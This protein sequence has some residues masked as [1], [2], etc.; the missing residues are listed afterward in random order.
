MATGPVIKTAAT[1]PS[2]T[3]SGSS[4]PEAGVPIVALTANAIPGDRERCL[5]AGMNAHVSKPTSR[6][7]LREALE[8]WA[9]AA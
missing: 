8:Q 9:R 4:G 6:E 1:R 7:L 5:A 3:I 2:R